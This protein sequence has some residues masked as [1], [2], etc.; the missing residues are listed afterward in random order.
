MLSMTSSSQHPHE[1][2]TAADQC[3]RGCRRG[4]DAAH[5]PL[6]SS[7]ET[8]RVRRHGGFPSENCLSLHCPAAVH[9]ASCR[10]LACK[11]RGKQ[12][13]AWEAVAK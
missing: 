2:G 9:P 10:G 4:K 5:L 11:T 8:A 12:V 7:Y 6:V 3:T 1:V 13:G